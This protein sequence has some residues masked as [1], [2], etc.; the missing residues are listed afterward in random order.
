M[1]LALA[2]NFTYT[3]AGAGLDAWVGLAK[4]IRV[5]T[6]GGQPYPPFVPGGLFI[7]TSKAT[8]YYQVFGN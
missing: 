1:S 2:S 5:A 7:D 3:A 8:S 6:R 4:M